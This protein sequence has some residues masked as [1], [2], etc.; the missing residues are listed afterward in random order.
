[1]LVFLSAHILSIICPRFDGSIMI[2]H[3]KHA[4]SS[5]RSSKLF[6]RRVLEGTKESITWTPFI[7]LTFVVAILLFIPSFADIIEQN[8]QSV[9][10]WTSSVEYFVQS[11]LLCVLLLMM[12]REELPKTT[13]VKK[14]S[15]DI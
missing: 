3:W 13:E 12:T 11:I 9:H 5:W 7:T 6:G 10:I 2:N 15:E 1:M 8:I 14:N 4:S